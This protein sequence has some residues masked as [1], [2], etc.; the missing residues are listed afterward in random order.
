MQRR[1]HLLRLFVSLFVLAAF[2]VSCAPP[3]QE[4]VTVQSTA[5]TAPTQ[6]VVSVA[7]ATLAPTLPPPAKYKEAPE[8]AALVEKGQLPPVEER[9]PENPKVVQPAES[10][11]QYGGV[12]RRL[13]KPSADGAMFTR[14][15]LYTSLVTWTT[16]W[17]GIQPDV[18][19]S[20]EVSEDASTYTFHLR[21]G[22]KWSDGDD[23]TSEDIRYWWEDVIM[24]DELTPAKPGWLKVNGELPTVT[25]PDDYTVVFQWKTANGLF[26]SRLATPD[27]LELV[28]VPS[29]WAKQFHTKY[30]D[31]AQIEKWQKD[32]Q[33][34]TWRDFYNYKATGDS[35]I[36]EAGRPS[37]NPWFV[38][39]GYVGGATQVVFERNPYFWKVDTDGQQLPYINRN[40]FRLID[41]VD[42]MVPMAL[43]GEVDQQDR[44]IATDPNKPLFV[45]NATK[46]GYR[47]FKTYS[48]SLNRM[49]IMFNLNNPDP[50]KNE[51]FNN[52]DFRI[53]LSYAIDRQEIID[54]VYVGVGEPWQTAPLQNSPFYDEEL[55]KQY[56]Q[57]DLAKAAEH[58][59][60]AGYTLN[61]SGKRIGPDGKPISFIVEV[62]D[63]NP[64]WIDML[65]MIS[66]YWAAVGI[67]MQPKVLERS[68]FYANKDALLHDAGVW[69]TSGFLAEVLLDP[70]YFIPYSNE[71]IW[72]VCWANWY[73]GAPA[74]KDC[75]PPAVV[76]ESLDLYKA[77]NATADVEE[78]ISL[79]KQ[80]IDIAKENFWS[81]G[82]ASAPDAYG[83]VKTNLK[84]FIDH[85]GGW[86]YPNP[87]PTMPETWYYD[88]P[89]P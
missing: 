36:R 60:K 12:L 39:S 59:D 89:Q 44:H 19:E 29:H 78:Q 80:M 24:N 40:V 70:R 51:I 84:N 69:S 54:T 87:A 62:I 32:G 17:T 25:F 47:F 18:A 20:F 55:A 48:G 52:K 22:M 83:I 34:E 85:P 31:K 88:P 64:Q 49:S 66:K 38:T 73:N 23:Y 26:L 57:F 56:V 37:I 16:D 68:I 14:T 61:A 63:T 1:T 33:Y 72:A 79:G 8:L 76:K 67:D 4:A 3:T 10:I 7:T 13:A 15:V 82:V 5:T 42:A 28:R 9:L 21:K 46:G 27:G 75:E 2:L 43:N 58:L 77:I 35:V 11:G 53:G 41:S 74:G 81:I 45:D 86:L 65:N 71:S 30:G 50:V 6:A